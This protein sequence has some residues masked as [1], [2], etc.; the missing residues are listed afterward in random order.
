MWISFWG[1]GQSRRSS[2]NIT[3]PATVNREIACFKTIFNKAIKNDKAERNP[4]QGVKLLKENNDRDRIRSP[5][6][7]IRL[8]DASPAHLKPI[9][10]LAYYTAM[11]QGEILSLA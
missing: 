11:R 3:K 4:A 6:E 9:I 2:K 1:A 8:L 5:D 10:K 7:L